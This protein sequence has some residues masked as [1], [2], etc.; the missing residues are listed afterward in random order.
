MEHWKQG[1]LA[2]G[3][4][5]AGKIA[6][7]LIEQFGDIPLPS[8][9]TSV[10]AKTV[11]E[12]PIETP[13][14]QPPEAPKMYPEISLQEERI[15]QIRICIGFGFH[16]KL[17]ITEEKYASRFPEFPPQPEN[18]KEG[19]GITPVLVE[20]GISPEDQC[21]LARIEYVSGGLNRTDW[22]RTLNNYETPKAPYAAWLEDGRNNL[23]RKPTDIRKDLETGKSEGFGGT[24]IEGLALYMSNPKILDHHFLDL[25]G[26][27]VE[28]DYSASLFL[29]NGRP[30]LSCS[31]TD[32]ADPRFGS[33]VRGSQK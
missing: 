22:N 8:V 25:P 9:A 20:T 27:T 19:L 4:S 21:R 15:R 13:V 29:W 26:T 18:Y 11:A 16:T 33:V 24:D 7:G 1:Q 31:F 30:R 23:N 6:E 14:A 32:H 5:A 2:K 28:S 12:S 3:N 10:E 17:G